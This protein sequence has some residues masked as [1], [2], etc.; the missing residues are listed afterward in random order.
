M[1]NKEREMIK[2]NIGYK[3]ENYVNKIEWLR[4]NDVAKQ[5]PNRTESSI[6]LTSCLN[7]NDGSL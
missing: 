4:G 2:E 5:E 7:P 1:K 6:N 3:V